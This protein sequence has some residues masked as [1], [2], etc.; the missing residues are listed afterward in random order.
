MIVIA[1]KIH[2]LVRVYIDIVCAV[3][4]GLILSTFYNTVHYSE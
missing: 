4:K 1:Y 3:L 2:T